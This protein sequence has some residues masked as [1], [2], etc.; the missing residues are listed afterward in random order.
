MKLLPVSACLPVCYPLIL[1]GLL[2]AVPAGLWADAVQ[3]T[4]LNGTSHAGDLLRLND[5]RLTLTADGAEQNIPLTQVL[6]IR[7]GRPA[8]EA[9]AP[10]VIQV[11]LLNGSLL[12]GVE[13]SCNGQHVVLKSP[14]L[15]QLSIPLAQVKAVVLQ[16][17]DAKS[18][19][20]WQT[21]LEKPNTDDMLVIKKGEILDFLPGVIMEYNDREVLFLYQGSEIPVK[22]ERVYGMIHP[23]KPAG[24]ST[25]VGQLHTVAGDRLAVQR[26]ELAGQ[27]FQVAIGAVQALTVPVA[28]TE[29][30]DFSLGRVVY[31][32]D[33]NP[34][35][36]E[37][38]PFFDTIWNYQRDKTNIAGPLRLN[39]KTYS[40]GLWIHSK[41]RLTY[42]LAGEFTQLQGV[43]GI[44]D[45]V[46][47]NGLGHVRCTITADDRVLFDEDIAAADAPRSLELD[48]KG[49]RFLQ[50]LVD[51]GKGLDIGDHLVIGDARLIK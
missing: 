46:A 26:L 31:L 15:G 7:T 3:V 32:S 49:V 50:I 34:E 1:C 14:L 23:R 37:H 10:P 25:A 43:L 27:E 11:Q 12:R 41:T 5:Q 42:R 48:L 13:A 38:T 4:E 30:I 20:M 28:G 29:M 22:R 19:A 47:E 36:V 35:G 21:L 39:G 2:C 18:L 44:D 17:T 9:Q 6:Q 51:F 24:K 33:M 8:E 45:A 16:P 40:K